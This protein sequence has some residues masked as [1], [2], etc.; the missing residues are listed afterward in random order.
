MAAPGRR[1]HT[2]RLG[3]RG[4]ALPEGLRLRVPEA[5]SGLQG[6]AGAR[7]WARAA[8]GAAQGIRRGSERVHRR[9]EGRSM[10]FFN[11][12]LMPYRHVDLDAIERHGSAWVTF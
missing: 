1:A 7:M 5:H 11:F 12:L 10:K 6:G 4:P 3:R 2:A 8:H 9:H